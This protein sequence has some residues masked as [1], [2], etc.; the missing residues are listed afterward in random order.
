[1][2]L[3][4]V[5]SLILKYDQLKK[6]IFWVALMLGS[7]IILSSCNGQKNSQ[8]LSKNTEKASMLGK[9]VSEL[10]SVIW[11]IFQDKND[12]FWFGSKE[13]GL[14]YYNGQQL[15]HFSKKD[16]LISN[17]IRG[18]QEDSSGNIYIETMNG[19]NQF[20]GKSFKTLE[21]K[22]AA[23][24]TSEWMLNSEDLWFKIGYTNKGP[25]RYDGKYLHY[26]EFPK[27]PQEDE[28]FRQNPKASFSPYGLYLIYKDPNGFIWF[29]TSSVGLCRYNGKS[30]QWHYEEQLQKTLSGGDFG[31]RS[32]FQDK[33][34]NF[35][36]NNSRHRYEI[37][38]T[39]SKHSD[40]LNYKKKNGIG[41]INNDKQTEFPYFLSITQDNDGDL[42]MVTYQNGVW[43][44]TGKKLVH[45]PVKDGKTDVLLFSI[46]KD[47]QG[48]LWLGTQNAGVFKYNGKSFEKFNFK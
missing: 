17:E 30:I 6:A 42:W 2:K 10:D 36:F 41:F 47:N 33:E 14:F 40:T 5:K 24:S 12:N 38:T 7:L 43:R 22:E 1:M 48:G 21:I 44:N 39:K 13:N 18:I 35:W 9:V 23:S 3:A 28:F 16:G 11:S 25:Y 26:L 4:L 34:E 27:S 29:G 31:I 19:I 46:F 45:Y 32:I 20:D 8:S 15:R 37:L